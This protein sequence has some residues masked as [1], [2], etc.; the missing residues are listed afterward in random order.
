MPIPPHTDIPDLAARWQLLGHMLLAAVRQ[1]LR[2]ERAGDAGALAKAE[3]LELGVRIALAELTR[4]LR[5]L[6]RQREIFTP[7]EQIAYEHLVHIASALITLT[8][9]LGYVSGMMLPAGRSCRFGSA[10]H[11][12][13]VRLACR[14]SAQAC[15]GGALVCMARNVFDSS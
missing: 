3:R 5:D 2:M 8:F 15:A 9:V 13:D 4:Q 7:E 10:R 14:P 11:S 12:R 1:M 6:E